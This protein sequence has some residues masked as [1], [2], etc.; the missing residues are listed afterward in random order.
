[1]R[2]A[3]FRTADPK[4]PATK[5]NCTAMVSHDWP[6]ADSPHS[7]VNAGTTAEAENQ[8]DIPRSS[9][10]ESRRIGLRLDTGIFRFAYI[11]KAAASQ[12]GTNSVISGK[13]K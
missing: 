3:R 5:P 8:T 10:S 6:E 12:F 9:A 7:L 1:M 11:S 13:S 2:S 4:A